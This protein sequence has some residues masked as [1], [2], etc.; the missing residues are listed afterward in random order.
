[1]IQNSGFENRYINAH[2]SSFDYPPDSMDRT[3]IYAE[4][5]KSGIA[6]DSLVQLEIFPGK[7]SESIASSTSETPHY[8]NIT[9]E[10][11]FLLLIALIGFSLLKNLLRCSFS[12]IIIMGISPKLLPETEKRQIDRNQWAVNLLAFVSCLLLAIIF[13]GTFL[14]S[15]FFQ[16]VFSLSFDDSLSNFPTLL[17]R[18]VI[19]LGCIAV[20]FG[21]F[22]IKRLLLSFFSF[23][24][25]ISIEIDEYKKT[26]NIFLA[27]FSPIG[28]FVAACVLFAPHV[29][30]LSAFL[31]G[32]VYFLSL[33][34]SKLIII[35]KRV[36]YPLHFGNIHIFLYLCTLEILPVL[37][38]VKFLI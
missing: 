12:N 2:T 15:D 19:F 34:V 26:S 20:I 27:S 18:A 23:T 11:S 37:V 1:M 21:L 14:R 16:N 8:S 17:Q 22:L 9:F 5:D 30:S 3:Y 24:F 29:I 25:D 6:P 38:L 33:F 13:Y 28:L 36:F 32:T 31:L 35:M 7:K 4:I 10:F